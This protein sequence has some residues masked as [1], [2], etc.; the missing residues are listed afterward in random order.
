MNDAGRQDPARVDLRAARGR[1]GA[2]G[3]TGPAPDA[4]VVV[5][6]NR[7][8][9]SRTLPRNGTIRVRN[10]GWAP[11]IA[12]AFP[13]RRGAAP[14][15]VGT[16]LRRIP[17]GRPRPPARPPQ[18]GGGGER[19]HPRRRR[20]RTRS[21]STGPARTCWCASWTNRSAAGHVPLRARAQPRRL[22]AREAAPIGRRDGL[23]ERDARGAVAVAVQRRTDHV[24]VLRA[25]A[26]PRA[27]P[28]APG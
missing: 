9:G 19:D 11:H 2:H 21:A 17:P 18:Y 25:R 26:R 4:Q 22:R 8:R 24:G 15:A 5:R 10:V 16:A 27:W 23:V 1:G 12:I 20:G 7:F 13:L 28:A 6:D 3:R 14:G